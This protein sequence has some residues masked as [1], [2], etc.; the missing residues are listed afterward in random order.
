MSLLENPLLGE[1][2]YEGDIASYLIVDLFSPRPRH[3]FLM[4]CST[5]GAR[6]IDG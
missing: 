2:E 6:A 4:S 5:T 3:P 1:Q